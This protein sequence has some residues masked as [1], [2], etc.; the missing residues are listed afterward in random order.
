M[1]QAWFVLLPL[2]FIS[3]HS[4]Y[5]DELSKLQND[6]IVTIAQLGGVGFLVFSIDRTLGLFDRRTAWYYTK[7]WIREFFRIKPRVHNISINVPVGSLS[8]VGSVGLVINSDG[9]LE[10]RI[11]QLEQKIEN[12]MS[13]LK[14][15]YKNLND[16]ISEET[17]LIRQEL[18]SVNKQVSRLE[19]SVRVASVGDLTKQVF[20]SILLVYGTIADRFLMP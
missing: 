20:G 12:L 17:Q 3:M 10:G 18:N 19:N 5:M 14:E 11:R 16:R 15:Q 7:S 9:S 8:M 4:I 6:I 13:Q 2:L 1:K